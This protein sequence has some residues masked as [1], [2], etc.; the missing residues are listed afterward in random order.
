MLRPLA[1]AVSICGLVLAMACSSGG[2]KEASDGEQN[3]TA[4]LT[5]TEEAGGITVEATWLTEAA[6]DEVDTDI[7]P[8]PLDEYVLLQIKLDTHSGDLNEIDL[9]REAALKQGATVLAP[10]AWLSLSDDS[11]HREG[12]LV[13]PRALQNGEVKLTLPIQD[14]EVALLW[15]AA[16]TT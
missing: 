14:E 8:Y 16:P 3:A 6:A 10:Q 4:D 11:H 1:Y 13:F 9:E 2:S 7:S 5:R 15:E 12:V